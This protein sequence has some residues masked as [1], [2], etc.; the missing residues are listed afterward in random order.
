MKRFFIAALGAGVVYALLFVVYLE[1]VLTEQLNTEL[2]T[3]FAKL[4]SDAP[5]TPEV[6]EVAA[7]TDWTEIARHLLGQLVLGLL[8]TGVFA[9]LARKRP[10]FRAARIAGASIWVLAFI[11]WPMF[12][13]A[14]YGMSMALLCVTI[15]Y[16]LVQTQVAA[17]VGA[18]LWGKPKPPA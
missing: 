13:L 18:L 10:R 7:G 17:H 11:V 1:I 15:G 6:A 9:A 16:G 5:A 12:L 8:T 14:K 4:Q 3:L 2:S